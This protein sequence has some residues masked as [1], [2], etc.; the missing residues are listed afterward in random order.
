ML[1]EATA[2][3]TGVPAE[4][5]AV[6]EHGVVAHERLRDVIGDDHRTHRRIG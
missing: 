3:A 4:R 5:E 1:A 2:A 6:Y